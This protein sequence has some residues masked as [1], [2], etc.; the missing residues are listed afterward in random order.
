MAVD[1][2]W[3]AVKNPLKTILLWEITASLS[4]TYFLYPHTNNNAVDNL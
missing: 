2:L 3:K 4:G 1:N